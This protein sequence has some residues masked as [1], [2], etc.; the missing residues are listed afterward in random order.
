LSV[1]N[2]LFS[3]TGRIPR[4]TYWLWLI[5][6]WFVL[7]TVVGILMGATLPA[8]IEPPADPAVAAPA[9]ITTANEELP[10]AFLG[11]LA[12]CGLLAIPAIWIALALQAK[13]WHDRGKSAAWILINLI[14][15]V[16][17]LWTFIEC[18]CLRGTV[19]PNQFGQDPT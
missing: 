14:P 13:R 3:F 19:G 7:S 17:G 18:G 11:A 1:K 5:V 9:E 6:T 10:A 15:L 4:R 2:I 12:V 16:G 8:D